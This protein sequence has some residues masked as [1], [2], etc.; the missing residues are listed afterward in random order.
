[1]EWGGCR[2]QRKGNF[3]RRGAEGAEKILGRQKSRE[4]VAGRK[5]G[6]AVRWKSDIVVKSGRFSAEE[7]K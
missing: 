6:H 2:R 5:F 1:M 3:K 7:K 4:I